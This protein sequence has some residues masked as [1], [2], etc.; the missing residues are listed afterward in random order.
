MDIAFVLGN[1]ISRRGLPLHDMSKYGHI[2]GCNALF[3]DFTPHV[4][5]ATDKPIAM[6]IE[7]TGYSKTN[8]FYTRRPTAG[9][10]SQVIPKPYYGF[11]SG[12]V[13]VA[14]AAL[15]RYPRIYLLGF[16]VGPNENQQFNN[17]YASTEFYKAQGSAA[18]Y[19]GNWTKQIKQI[20][21]DFPNTKFIRVCGPTTARLTE[22]DA[23]KNMT[24]LP[25]TEFIDR[26][27]KLKDF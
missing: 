26:L 6:H 24:H 20:C 4:L 7:E 1:G 15:E 27:N 3:R 17:L 10:G 12:P 5:V 18:T 23:I 21:Q 22:L 8:T 14:L 13:A 2:Y 16:D 9:S 11:S 19:T 25:L